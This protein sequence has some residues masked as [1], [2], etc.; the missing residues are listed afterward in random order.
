MLHVLNPLFGCWKFYIW[1]PGIYSFEKNLWLARYACS[2]LK[3]E[4]F[5]SVIPRRAGKFCGKP[6]L[7]KTLCFWVWQCAND[8]FITCLGLELHCSWRSNQ[9]DIQ[10]MSELRVDWSTSFWNNNNQLFLEILTQL[11]F[12]I[13]RF[14]KWR[15]VTKLVSANCTLVKA[16]KAYKEWGWRTTCHDLIRFCLLGR[17]FSLTSTTGIALSVFSSMNWTSSFQ[18]LTVCGCVLKPVALFLAF[19]HHLVWTKITATESR[20]GTFD[21]LSY[22]KA[23]VTLHSGTITLVKIKEIVIILSLANF[24][25]L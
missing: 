4:H 3:W 13:E 7:C 19:L 23:H 1:Q 25:M 21:S 8:V 22:S 5:S 10:W 15:L 6:L 12:L 11:H 9:E 24:C 14:L 16:Y 20:F 2:A 18:F 17:Y